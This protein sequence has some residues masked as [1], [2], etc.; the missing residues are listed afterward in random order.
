MAVPLLF[1][2][3]DFVRFPVVFNGCRGSGDEVNVR[4][5]LQ[6]EV[7]PYG[8]YM[9]HR[10][11]VSLDAIQD[12]QY[13]NYLR[14]TPTAL[15]I[16][17][18]HDDPSE[19]Y[20]GGL[21]RSVLRK[22]D[23]VSSTDAAMLR[24]VITGKDPDS[25]H[26]VARSLHVPQANFRNFPVHYLYIVGLK[27]QGADGPES[28]QRQ[29]DL[30]Q[31]GLKAVMAQAARDKVSNLIVPCVGVFEGDPT[32]LQPKEFFPVVFAATPASGR[33]TNVYLSLYQSWE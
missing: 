27:F 18:D 13:L 4:T 2:A 17:I 22:L 29:S 1:L 10:F 11:Y 31:S 9:G 5:L 33:P 12:S 23:V 20:W 3:V 15:V 30:L 19:T 8:S 14:T 16:G 24:A 25:G 6:K 28:R 26:L 21:T 7:V 32:T